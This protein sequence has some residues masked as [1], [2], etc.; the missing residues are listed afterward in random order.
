MHCIRSSV[1]ENSRPSSH[2]GHLLIVYWQCLV[3]I[4]DVGDNAHF[5]MD[6]KT[7]DQ[8]TIVVINSR[9]IYTIVRNTSLLYT[10][11]TMFLVIN[12]AKKLLLCCR[13]SFLGLTGLK[14]P[15]RLDES[16]VTKCCEIYS[17]YL[18]HHYSSWFSNTQC[19][20]WPDIEI[21][22]IAFLTNNLSIQPVQQCRMYN[23]LQGKY[24]SRRMSFL[25]SAF[26]VK[27]DI[28]YVISGIISYIKKLKK[29]K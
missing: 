6:L 4:Q 17:S 3:Q 1:W 27:L 21:M 7:L 10:E 26:N 19:A 23:D 22:A 9:A 29:W 18:I 12:G 5:A 14:G 24:K 2:H 20:Y 15:D 25:L 16:N 11:E 8:S 13:Q 28:G